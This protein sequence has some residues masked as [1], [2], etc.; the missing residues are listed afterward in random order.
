ML[1]VSELMGT[2]EVEAGHDN[3][4]SCITPR[5]SDKVSACY[6]S[7]H[8]L[9]LSNTMHA[10]AYQTY[11]Y[12]VSH[13]LCTVGRSRATFNPASIPAISNSS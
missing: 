9:S 12:H 6:L 10:P 4:G 3:I 8:P 11:M 2:R 13:R 5:R 7:H 1:G